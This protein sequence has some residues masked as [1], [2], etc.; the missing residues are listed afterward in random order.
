[1]DWEDVALN[2]Y[3]TL[4]QESLDSIS[5]AQ[6]TLRAGVVAL[7]VLAGLAIKVTSAGEV[8]QAALAIGGAGIAATVAMQWLLE[9]LRSARAGSHIAGLEE[10]IARRGTR[11]G[12]RRDPPL[13][14]ERELRTPDVERKQLLAYHNTVLLSL[15]AAALPAVALGL[16]ALG[17]DEKWVFLGIAVTGDAALLALTIASIRKNRAELWRLYC[18]PPRAFSREPGTLASAA[19][20]EQQSAPEASE[21]E[22]P[23][24][25]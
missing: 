20:T 21:A 11:H 24:P 14:W 6:A 8:A 9:T 1:M 10:A 4:R 3:R 23:A 7:G 2:E 5:Q 13:R 12:W 18:D 16:Y 19:R 17:D 22:R 25:G 15:L